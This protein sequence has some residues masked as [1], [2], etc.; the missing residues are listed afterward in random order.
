MAMVKTNLANAYVILRFQGG[1]RVSTEQTLLLSEMERAYNHP[2][3]AD[4]VSDVE[5]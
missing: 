3:L 2:Q 1:G 5:T 4:S